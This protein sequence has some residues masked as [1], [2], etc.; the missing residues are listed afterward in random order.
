MGSVVQV[1]IGAG[2]LLLP[3]LEGLSLVD[4]GPVIRRVP[5]ERDVQ[6]FQEEIHPCKQK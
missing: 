3:I 6:I 4:A 2:Q 1:V 5:P